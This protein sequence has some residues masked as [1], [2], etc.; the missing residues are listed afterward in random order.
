MLR[1]QLSLAILALGA[2]LVTTGCATT[3]PASDTTPP[4]VRLTVIGAGA[5]FTLTPTSADESRTVSVP[6]DVTMLASAKDEQGVKNVWIGGSIRVNC[7][8]GDIGQASFIEYLANNPE[9]PSVGVG[10]Q[11]VDQRLTSLKIE[12]QHLVGLCHDGFTFTGASG[13]FR[14]SG[15]NFHGGVTDT[16]VF[17]LTVNP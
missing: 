6:D 7:T 2:L 5:T 9:D 3:V 14:A 12:S 15:E 17:S 1:T 10:D 13:S 8:S 16:A 4:D 11:A